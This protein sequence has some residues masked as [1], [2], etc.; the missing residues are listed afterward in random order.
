MNKTKKLTDHTWRIYKVTN[1]T[2]TYVGLTSQKLLTRLAQHKKG[3][4]GYAG[5]RR[6]PHQT[7]LCVHTQ[8]LRGFAPRDMENRAA[9]PSQRR[10][11]TGIANRGEHEEETRNIQGILPAGP[12]AWVL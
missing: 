7:A 5:Q 6:V 9:P 11:S 2:K 10:P 4:A 8:V 12:I 1:G 3:G